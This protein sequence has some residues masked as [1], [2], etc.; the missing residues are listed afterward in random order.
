MKSELRLPFYLTWKYLQRGRRWTL[1]LTL[2]LMSVAFINLV[3]ISSL[4]NGIIQGTNDQIINTMT[5]N[6]Y[7]TP[8]LGSDYITNQ[9]QFLSRLRSINGITGTSAQLN[10]PAQ[11]SFKDISGNWQILAV[12]PQDE[13]SV[14]NIS[15]KIIAGS[16]LNSNDD[17][18]ILIGR[19]IAGGPGVEE[20]AFSFKGAKVGDKVTITYGAGMTKVFTIKG[21]FETKFMQTDERAFITESALKEMMPN[22]DGKATTVVVKINNP[23]D[24]N[25]I[26][27][28]IKK[29][30]IDGQIYTWKDAAGL[31][32]SV[33]DSFTSIN[34]LMSFVG[35]LIAAITVFIVIYVDI[36]N[37][38]RQI[39][40]LRAVGIKPYIIIFSYVI[41][42]AVYAVIGVIFGTAIFYIVLV[43]YFNVHPFSLPIC[44]AV[45]MLSNI[46]YIARTEAI[47]WVSLFS[48]LIPSIIVTKTKMLDAILGR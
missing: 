18:Q 13:A 7:I 27:D 3:F 42:S 45:L 35:I 29:S 24:S 40:I 21:I 19:Q 47:I 33:S 37:K 39:G 16:Y 43:P 6:I 36:I 28:T 5:G 46:D 44:D 26:I 12:N 41:L 32:T 14:T 11:L 25:N 4:F 48:G 20:N 22:L 17:N 15:K 23:N 34:I 2:F 10:L 1:F 31:M 9:D 30:G 8:P 38:K